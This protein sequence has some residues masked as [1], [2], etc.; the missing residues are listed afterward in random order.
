MIFHRVAPVSFLIAC[1]GMLGT[2]PA[3]SFYC[4][5]PRQPSCIDA[6]GTFDNEW[7]FNSCRSDMERYVSDVARYAACLYEEAE[8]EADDARSEA[9]DAIERFNCR[10]QGGLICP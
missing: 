2:T 5:E 4:S 8:R 6:F 9:N 1:L 7:S 10:A 3:Q